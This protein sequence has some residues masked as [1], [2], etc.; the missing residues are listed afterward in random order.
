MFDRGYG[1]EPLAAN[2]DQYMQAKTVSGGRIELRITNTSHG[3]CQ[4]YIVTA[5]ALNFPLWLACAFLINIVGYCLHLHVENS[6]LI[7]IVFIVLISALVVKLNFRVTKE[8]LL[9]VS[10]VGVQLTTTFASGRCVSK[11]YD[12]SSVSGVVINEAVTMYR[13]IHYMALLL[14]LKDDKPLRSDSAQQPYVTE[15][16]PLFTHS[17]PSLRFLQQMR[18]NI[19]NSL[20]DQHS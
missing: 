3:L 1:D 13:V 8:A 6:F 19:T 4:E 11:F 2:E 14:S 17:W 18:S 16:V 15:L 10:S 5:P 12:S 7:A 9:V 20:N